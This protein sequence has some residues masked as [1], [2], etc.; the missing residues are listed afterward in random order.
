MPRNAV[1]AGAIRSCVAHAVAISWIPTLVERSGRGLMTRKTRLAAGVAASALLLAAEA[2]AGG[3][4]IREQSAYGLG[5]A[6]AGIAAG[7]PSLSSMFWN[8]ATITQHP[9][10][11]TEQNLSLVWAHGSID[12]F[13]ANR[14]SF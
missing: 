6:F 2:Q 7:G 8:P 5:E 4:Y 12:V 14:P 1:S 3:F 10:F 9:G 13:Q 11:Q